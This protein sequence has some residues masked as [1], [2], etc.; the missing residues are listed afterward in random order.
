MN[1]LDNCNSIVENWSKSF[2]KMKW[3]LRRSWG[4][5]NR[6]TMN[7]L[8]NRYKRTTSYLMRWI[9]LTRCTNRL[10]QH[11]RTNMRRITKWRGRWQSWLLKVFFWILKKSNYRILWGRI[12]LKHC[13][14]NWDSLSI[15]YKIYWD[16]VLKWRRSR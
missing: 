11:Y 1:I 7:N 5:Q 3:V 10:F 6:D 9:C 16:N 12:I 8:K 14:K 4:R 2:R 13:R 15:L